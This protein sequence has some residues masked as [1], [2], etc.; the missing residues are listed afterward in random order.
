MQFYDHLIKKDHK[1]YR[2]AFWS[3]PSGDSRV[4]QCSCYHYEFPGMNSHL[5]DIAQRSIANLVI[6]YSLCTGGGSRNFDLNFF[7]RV[8][9]YI[10]L[11]SLRFILFSLY[12]FPNL[13]WEFSDDKAY[14]YDVTAAILVFQNNETAAMVVF[15]TN[16][17]GVELFSYVKTF[18][19]SNKLAQMLAT[20]VKTLY[21][22][23]Y[24][25]KLF[26]GYLYPTLRHTFL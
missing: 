25:I 10:Y 4:D 18:F 26:S 23:E 7:V 3:S 6:L 16:P 17:V 22:R 5:F 14:S 12:T 13:N 24:D 19:C 2:L 21:Q 8:E 11:I 1:W 15:Q 9:E 20:L